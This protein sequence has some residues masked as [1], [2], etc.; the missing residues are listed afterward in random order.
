MKLIS[1]HYKDWQ[2][3]QGTDLKQL[4]MQFGEFAS[5]LVENWK[6]ENLLSEIILMEGFPLDSTIEEMKTI[7]T[8]KIKQVTSGFHEH[9]LLICLDKKIAYAT[10]QSLKLSGDDVF[11][12][13]DSAITD[14][15]K[16]QLADKGMIKTI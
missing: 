2:N 1:S 10:I 5:P 7:K 13:L 4:E 11:I 8:N 9:R 14:Q 12:C 16:V 3:F 15:D 6:E